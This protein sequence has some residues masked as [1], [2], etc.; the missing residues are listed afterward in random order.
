MYFETHVL[1]HIHIICMKGRMEATRL[2]L[3]YWQGVVCC[4]IRCQVLFTKNSRSYQTFGSN[5]LS[6]G[7]KLGDWI[8]NV[9]QKGTG[10]CRVLFISFFEMQQH[11]ELQGQGSTFLFISQLSLSCNH[12]AV[13]V[14]HLDLTIYVSA[15]NLKD[16][17]HKT[18]L[19][20]LLLDIFRIHLNVPF[21]IP[22]SIT[23]SLGK[24]R[25]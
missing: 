12:P 6:V 3:T 23:I 22:P 17:N 16:G 24:V 11:V 15:F 20:F 2:L 10:Q 8:G 14:V 5:K 13:L 21:I 4:N 25:Q 1:F 18:T 9:I 7:V 19:S